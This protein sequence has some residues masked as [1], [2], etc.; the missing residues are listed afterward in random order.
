MASWFQIVVGLIQ[1]LP[2][3]GQSPIRDQSGVIRL[4]TGFTE[5]GNP[6]SPDIEST[7]PLESHSSLMYPGST[8]FENIVGV[9]T[10]STVELFAEDHVD[11]YGRSVVVT[12]GI[13]HRD[14]KPNLVD[15]K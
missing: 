14:Y 12:D 1:D 6:N 2:M 10:G 15:V 5:A 4:E 13:D 3:H 11:V 7:G 8:S 9:V